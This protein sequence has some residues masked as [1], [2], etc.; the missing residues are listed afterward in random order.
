VRVRSVDGC[1]GKGASIASTMPDASTHRLNVCPGIAAS[2]RAAL[3]AVLLTHAAH[4]AAAGGHHSVDDA[5]RIEPGHCQV[6]TWFDRE[7]GNARALLHVGPACRVGPVDIGLNV[8]RVRLD[9]VGTTTALGLE[10]KWARALSERWSVGVV[11]ASIGQDRSPHLVG[12]SV[13]VPVTWQ[14][15][16]TV[17]A[18]VD[19]GRDFRH[20]ERDTARAGL[21]LE[22]APTQAASFVAERFREGGLDFWRAGARWSVTSSTSVDLSRAENLHGAPSP[23]WTI[24]VNWVFER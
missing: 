16:E 4:A 10:V 7:R 1:G 3:A 5:A 20:R 12:S 17:R 18:H 15:G 23:W 14:A 2:A 21:A 24:G 6:E 13:I 11:L 9:G 8:D 19:I 22:W